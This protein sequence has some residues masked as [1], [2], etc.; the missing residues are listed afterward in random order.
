MLDSESKRA[1]EAAQVEHAKAAEFP[2]QVSPTNQP[3]NHR[4]DDE[5]DGD[6]DDDVKKVF[7]NR[8]KL[9]AINNRLSS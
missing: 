7:Q 9:D 1:S 3:T 8:I 4:D 2:T 5:C 6:F